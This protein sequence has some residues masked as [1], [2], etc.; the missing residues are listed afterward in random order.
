[1]RAWITIVCATLASSAAAAFADGGAAERCRVRVG[2]ERPAGCAVLRPPAVQPNAQRK[3]PQR[4]P[5]APNESWMEALR[6]PKHW[7]S[8]KQSTRLLMRELSRLERL[9]AVT[10]K[11]SAERARIVRRLADGYAELEHLAAVERIRAELHLDRAKAKER[12]GSD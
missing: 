10:P 9:L 12:A 2:H 8:Q 1:M 11:L 5:R 6:Y 3:A 7:S 4:A